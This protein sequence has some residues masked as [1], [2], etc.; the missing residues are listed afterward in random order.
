MVKTDTKWSYS[1]YL[2][3]TRP[4]IG[5]IEPGLGYITGDVLIF[6]L[7]IMVLFSLSVVRASGYFQVLYSALHFAYNKSFNQTM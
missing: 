6:V 7:V 3:T 5:W 4:G 1:E 2:F